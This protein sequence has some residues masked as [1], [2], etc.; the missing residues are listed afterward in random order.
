MRIYFYAQVTGSGTGSDSGSGG[1]SGQERDGKAAACVTLSHFCA[2]LTNAAVH[3]LPLTHTTRRH[4]TPHHTHTCSE[5]YAPP[6]ATIYSWHSTGS[7]AASTHPA[8][9]SQ[10]ILVAKLSHLRQQC[11]ARQRDLRWRSTGTPGFASDSDSE[12]ELNAPPA[13]ELR[14]EGSLEATVTLASRILVEI[15]T[16]RIMLVII[17]IILVMCEKKSF[18]VLFLLHYSRI[19]TFF[20]KEI[21]MVKRSV[22]YSYINQN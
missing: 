7:T 8:A 2:S 17:E 3:M 18:I 14:Q 21:H 13:G 12:S 4:T 22:L 11:Q 6:P 16:Q 15:Y 10:R 9:G 19:N 5:L 1:W 20:F